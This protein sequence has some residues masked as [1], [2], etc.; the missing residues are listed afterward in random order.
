MS[1]IGIFHMLL[2]K[3]RQHIVLKQNKIMVPQLPGEGP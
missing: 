2:E 3:Q 1:I